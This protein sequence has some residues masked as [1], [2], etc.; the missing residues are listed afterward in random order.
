MG[1]S[2]S[3]LAV[4]GAGAV[5]R[6]FAHE[7]AAAGMRLLLWSRTRAR[8]EELAAELASSAGGAPRVVAAGAQALG[9]AAAALLCVADDALPALAA[10]LAAALPAS[11]RA[12][13]AVVWHTSGAA[14]PAVLEPLRARGF[15]TGKL[16]PLVPFPP[17]PAGA[18]AAAEPGRSL[19]GAWFVT[20]GSPAA[21]RE[22]RLLI[23]ALGGRDLRLKPGADAALY[24]AAAALLS[25]GSVALLDLCAD[26]LAELAEDGEAARAAALA[27]LE[28]T[29]AN[30]RAH[31]ARDALTGPLA[32][33]ATELVREHLVRLD[34][35]APDAARLYRA[36]AARML[37]LAAERGS[38]APRRRAELEKLLLD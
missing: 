24:H 17:R 12:P 15:E 27:L 31:G 20:D 11:S 30:V 25:G 37:V 36:L 32:R 21:R 29:V 23:E 22:A 16:H 38:L 33:G 6:A 4:L 5:G 34:A 28:A 10:E 3:P 2:G 7:L 19:R 26:L 14:G 18:P 9:G 35:H 1:L 8:A 13:A